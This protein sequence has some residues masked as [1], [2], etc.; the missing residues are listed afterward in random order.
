VLPLAFTTDLAHDHQPSVNPDPDLQGVW[1]PP[2]EVLLG[3][4]DSKSG[5][6]GPQGIVFMGGGIAEVNEQPIS[7]VLSDMPLIPV[8]D[9]GTRRLVGPHDLAQLFGIELSG[10]GGGA[11]QV[12]K[13]D[14][15]LATLGFR[16]ALYSDTRLDRQGLS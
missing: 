4:E 15:E 12:T 8:N 3:G 9:L 5:P 7:Q 6:H 13:H 2:V 1:Y 16:G 14:G 11:H 10:E